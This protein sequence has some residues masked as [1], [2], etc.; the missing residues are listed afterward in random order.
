MLPLPDCSRPDLCKCKYQHWDDRRQDDR[1][2]YASGIASQYFDGEEKRAS[3]G[4]R[5]S[6]N[7]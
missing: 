3:N 5:K 6:D 1:R 7:Y 4:R 2:A